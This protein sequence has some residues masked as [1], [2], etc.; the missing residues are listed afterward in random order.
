MSIAR[1]VTKLEQR[2]A[3]RAAPLVRCVWV[4]EAGVERDERVGGPGGATPAGDEPE[5]GDLLLL[6]VDPHRV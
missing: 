4:D 6:G 2:K 1:R 3:A 5:D